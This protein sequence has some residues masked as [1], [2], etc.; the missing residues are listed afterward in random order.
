MSAKA[1]RT[2]IKGII[3]EWAAERDLGVDAL[4]AQIDGIPVIEDDEF[5]VPDWDYELRELKS[6]IGIYQQLPKT[7]RFRKALKKAFDQ[8]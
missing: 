1:E 8:L 3:R 5:E 4:L 6:A 7:Q 2:R